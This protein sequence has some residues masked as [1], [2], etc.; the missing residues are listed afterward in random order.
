MT[1]SKIMA[2]SNTT[3]QCSLHSSEIPPHFYDYHDMDVNLRRRLENS[4]IG[5][6]NN[7]SSTT[8]RNSSK[9]YYQGICNIINGEILR[10]RKL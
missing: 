5:N 2:V 7:A 4:E 8:K 3:D 10:F 1:N 6:S 9:H